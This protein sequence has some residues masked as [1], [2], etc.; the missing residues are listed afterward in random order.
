MTEFEIKSALKKT[1][2]DVQA[3]AELL[4]SAGE[5]RDHTGEEKPS[6]PDGEEKPSDLEE[7]ALSLIPENGWEPP[8]KRGRT[9][10][11]T[12]EEPTI[13]DWEK[14]AGNTP[15]DVIREANAEESGPTQEIS[16]DDP[17]SMQHMNTV[18]E[19]YLLDDP[20]LTAAYRGVYTIEWGWLLWLQEKLPNDTLC[21]YTSKTDHGTDL[22]YIDVEPIMQRAVLTPDVLKHL[23]ISPEFYTQIQECRATEKPRF[24]IGILSLP[25]HAN[26]LV[27]DFE[28]ETISRFEPNGGRDDT[29][30]RPAIID[31]AIRAHL[32]Q[33]EG[34]V[35]YT[36]F[37]K[38]EKN[39][40]EKNMF[41]D[42]TYNSPIDFCPPLGVQTKAT[43]SN[44][45]VIKNT[46]GY[47]LAWSMV[48]MHQRVLSPDNT[49]EEVVQYFLDM[50]P[51]A[52]LVLIRQYAA[53]MV[54]VAEGTLSYEQVYKQNDW[55]GLAAD[56]MKEK[57][58]YARIESYDKER[59]LYGIVVFDWSKNQLDLEPG[60]YTARPVDLFPVTDEKVLQTLEKNYNIKIGD[61]VE[62]KINNRLDLAGEVLE[63]SYKDDGIPVY[64]MDVERVYQDGDDRGQQIQVGNRV[65]ASIL[66][67][68]KRDFE[69]GDEVEWVTANENVRVNRG[70]GEINSKI[71]AHTYS[72]NIGGLYDTRFFNDKY[73]GTQILDALDLTLQ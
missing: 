35:G 57:Y 28:N 59:R 42:W 26:G 4:A 23:Y 16:P 24:V 71:G 17:P 10:E 43:H 11:P 33:G 3:A 37:G 1:H 27:F 55:V 14:I 44:L 34:F 73:Y 41:R 64:T 12:I 61:I 36:G 53:F 6:D 45:P 5:K 18:L 21:V 49:E 9:E 29:M 67:L 56:F 50:E 62:Y 46:G 63:R 65:V 38:R 51:N 54:S 47:C 58:G 52:L 2:G 7:L 72:V 48:F 22:L 39:D 32:I 66:N 31:S 13:E 20:E 70:W 60:R 69:G 8:K 25:Q 19:K 30:F 68:T 15:P 40:D